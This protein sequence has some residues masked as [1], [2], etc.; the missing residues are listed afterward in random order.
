MSRAAER[1]SGLQTLGTRILLS[2]AAAACAFLLLPAG[3]KGIQVTRILWPTYFSK[4]PETSAEARIDALGEAIRV[5][6]QSDFHQE[7]AA[8]FQQMAA[9][10]A[11]GPG[12]AEPAELAIADYEEGSRLHPYEPGLVI[13]RANLLSQLGRDAEAEEA[14]ARGIRLQGGMEPGFRGRFSLANHYLRKG[15]RLFNV[16]NP[17]P[18]QAALELAA[19]EIETAVDQ[20]H[21]VIADMIGP[22]VAIHE[23]LGTAREAAGDREGALESYNFAATLPNG[24]R[25]HYRAGVLIGK[26]A[27]DAWSKRRA[28]EA[29]AL[30]IQAR[31][32]IGQ[33]AN[34]LPDGVTLSQRAEYLA[35]LDRTIAFLKGAKVEPAK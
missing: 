25:T 34:S 7:R 11:G 17:D 27:V 13:N 28:A 30:F 21:W 19:G 33:A 31:Q 16:E 20:M 3:W 26:M 2:I 12:F 22:R 14:Y 10:Q 18:A 8:V 5:W 24:A 32:R 35:Y 15:L 29:M 6:P 4:H 23:S 9:A 1:P